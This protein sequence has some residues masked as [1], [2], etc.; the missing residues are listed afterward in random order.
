MFLECNWA[1]AKLNYSLSSLAHL[2]LLCY[3]SPTVLLLLHE[4]LSDVLI[5]YFTVLCCVFD[6][7]YYYYYYYYC[8][9]NLLIINLSSELHLPSWT[10]EPFL[11]GLCFGD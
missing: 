5:L 1:F 7:Q 11:V 3:N 10:L 8:F 4:N 2:L 9:T 6:T